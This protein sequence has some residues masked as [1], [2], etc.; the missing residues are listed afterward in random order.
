MSQAQ[1]QRGRKVAAKKRNPLV[2]FYWGVGAI[3][4]LGAAFLITYFVRSNQ[5]P[6]I[7]PVN[8]PVGQTAEGFW[9]KGSPDAK[10]T[11]IEYGD[12]QCPTCAYYEKNLGPIITRDYIETGKVQ[13]IYHEFP[14]DGHQHSVPS[15]EAARC[16]GDQSK[17]WEMHDMLFAN[18]SQ[19]ATLNN[20][21]NVFSG[22]AGQIGLNRGDFDAC[23]SAGTHRAAV[24]A[25]AQDSIAKG[26]T[27]TPTF[28]VNGQPVDLNGLPGAIEAALRAAGQ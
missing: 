21:S 4:V 15:A 11:V 3:V 2:P 13:F 9:Y 28:N 5:S 27:G 17:F 16:A 26:I 19:W 14:L 12:Y 22:Y 25:A 10:V 18:Q 24:T 7:V 23:M 6:S 20:V 8:A 1:S